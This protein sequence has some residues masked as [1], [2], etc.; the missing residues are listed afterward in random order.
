MSDGSGST[1]VSPI[2]GYLEALHARYAA[3]HEGEVA[4][5]I[6]ELAR[7]NPDWFSIC[8]A[9]C[10]GHVYQVGDAHQPFTIQSM[11]KPLVYGLALEDR[12][13]EAVLQRI[14]VEPTGDAFNSISLEPGSGRPLNP[15]INAGAIAA[16]GLVRGHSQADKLHRLQMMMS[17]YAGET[18]PIDK[19]TFRSERDTG[20]RNRAIGHMLR[21]FD[22][23]DSHPDEVLDLYFQQCSVLVTCRQLAMMAATLANGG[24]N[25]VTR[26]QALRSEFVSDVLSVMTTCG[27]YDYAGEWVYRVGMPAKSGVAGGVMAVLPGQLGIGVFSPRLDAHGNSVRGVE[28]C[29]DLSRDLSL[30]FL[31]PPRI[32]A[33]A[34]HSRTS[35]GTRRS[36]KR[37]TRSESRVLSE[38]GDEARILGLQGDLK[39]ATVEPV[40]RELSDAD[41]ASLTW[42]VLD[43]R[44]VTQIDPVAEHYL[45][46][47]AKRMAAQQRLLVFA[48][49]QHHP[50]LRRR[51]EEAS[52]SM[53]GL[54]RCLR[55]DV[56]DAL[57]WIENQIIFR[58]TGAQAASDLTDLSE[59]QFCEGMEAEDVRH[60]QGVMREERYEARETIVHRGEAADRLYFLLSGEASVYVQTAQGR[61]RRLATIVPGTGFGEAAFVMGS[62]R[63][64]DVVADRAV[65]CYSLTRQA[66]DQLD[67]SR[68]RLKIALLQNLL[69]AATQI[70]QQMIGDVAL[71]DL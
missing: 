47:C 2:L 25:P 61:R 57:E 58:H 12:G 30:H 64:A 51:I 6:P 24:V 48:E 1:S 26:E 63:S 5:Y 29:E 3:N 17:A 15:M 23:L 54:L 9:T 41:S 8:I 53:P 66:Y 7:A 68:G 69:R 33:G 59:H 44:K 40:V 20:H 16:A 19:V 4:T 27:M 18:L 21:N 56:D 31:Q 52:E 42:A 10:D 22:I 49:L 38:H 45:I 36:Q 32:A 46:E 50:R 55:V 28:V 43:L 35:L 37:R 71:N 60:L 34:I 62:T 67:Q 39:F 70:S 13:R 14:S 11:S 65:T